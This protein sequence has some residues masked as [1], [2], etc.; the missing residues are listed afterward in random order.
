MLDYALRNADKHSLL[1]ALGDIASRDYP[2]RPLVM[3]TIRQALEVSAS[4][5][6]PPEHKSAQKGFL[7]LAENWS[8][9]E[10][11]T[12]RNHLKLEMLAALPTI[13]DKLAPGIRGLFIDAQHEVLISG[14]ADE[15][16]AAVQKLAG[17]RTFYRTRPGP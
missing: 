11:E 6:D 9:K 10:I 7:F 2:V 12:L 14:N 16:L 5:P 1:S 8:T 4:K 17:A 3:E 15:R 13:A